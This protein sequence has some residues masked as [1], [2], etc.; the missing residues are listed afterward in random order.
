MSALTILP[1]K[2]RHAPTAIVGLDSGREL[3]LHSR[4]DPLEEAAFFAAGVVPQER[5]LYAV[6]GFGLGYHV[7]ALLDRIPASSHVVVLEPADFR[8]SARLLSQPPSRSTRWLRDTRLHF[9][10]HHDAQLTPIHLANT[11]ASHRLR[12]FT[13]VPH[14]P[15]MQTA[16]AFFGS[17]AREI[18]RALPPSVRQQLNTLDQ[19]LE[20]D[21]RNYWAN[22]SA[23]WNEHRASSL[24]GVWRDLPAVVVSGGPSLD[25]ALPLL[26]AIRDRILLIATGSTARTLLNHGLCPDLVVSVDPHDPNLAHFVGWDGSQIPLVCYHRFHRGIPRVYAGPLFVFDMQD[27]PP[28]P[29]VEPASPS[30]FRRGGTVAFSALQLAH[31][32]GANPIAF[33]GQDFAFARGRTH[34]AGAIYN[35]SFDE[36]QPLPEE[37]VRVPATAGG[38]VLTNRLLHA[39]LLHMQDYILHYAKVKPAVRHINTSTSGALILGMETKGLVES[40]EG[41]PEPPLA[42]SQAISQAMTA[43]RRPTTA[44][45]IATLDAWIATLQS[46]VASVDSVESFSDIFAA[47]AATPLCDLPGRGYRDLW[48]VFETKYQLGAHPAT[49]AFVSRFKSHL[50]HVLEDLRSVRAAS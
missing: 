20:S 1:T 26:P 41:C 13:V 21:L 3:L 6:L 19:M 15:S 36:N 46:L 23:S 18:Q 38:T 34:A 29:L 8:L 42:A 10:S 33:I 14:V 39:Y 16:E 40:I 44:T 7:Q 24:E 31:L 22:L 12:S 49:S 45:Q 47:F 50:R 4:I 25:E 17:L 27:E 48:F 43:P 2:V 9:L 32:V 28:L 37:C 5:T 11:L 30:P 35:L